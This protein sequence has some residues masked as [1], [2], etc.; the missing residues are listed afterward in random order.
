V[1]PPI[2]SGRLRRAP[3]RRVVALLCLPTL[4]LAL[5]ASA[6]LEK[7]TV[8]PLADGDQRR[9]ELQRKQ[10]DE[11]A[12]R[13]LGAHIRGGE[14][15]DLSVLQ[16]LLDERRVRAEDEAELQAMGVVLGDVMATRL[17]L[18]WVVVEDSAGRSRGLRHRNR[19]NLF[20]P[21]TMIWKRVR[22]GEAV[23][24]VALYED[25]AE[26]VRRLDARPGS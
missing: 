8:G 9:S 3:W 2:H 7:R 20:F 17:H 16:R 21:I 22:A 11:L 1:G 24:V 4:L 15:A 6:Q 25:M 10:V 18:E 13:Q 5:A 14:L 23:N 19:E 26:S 12:R